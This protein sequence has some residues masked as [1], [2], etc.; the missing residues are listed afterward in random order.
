MGNIPVSGNN[1]VDT[2]S[3]IFTDGNIMLLPVARLYHIKPFNAMCNM[4]TIRWLERPKVKFEYCISFTYYQR[5]NLQRLDHE[6]E[7]DFAHD[8]SNK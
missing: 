3:I 1:V 4:I 8:K 2:L 6:Y 5:I 7:V